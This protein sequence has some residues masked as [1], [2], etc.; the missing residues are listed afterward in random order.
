MSEGY[1]GLCYHFGEGAISSIL[2]DA[3]LLCIVEEREKERARE[4]LK[5]ISN[6]K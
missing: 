6:Q 3:S 1:I 5:E 2:C 4:R